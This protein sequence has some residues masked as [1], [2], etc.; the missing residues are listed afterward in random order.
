MNIPDPT[1]NPGP[2]ADSTTPAS[3]G[4]TSTPQVPAGRLHGHRRSI[5]RMALGAAGVVFGD[6]GT[7]P[8]YA[9]KET[10]GAHGLA[11]N[12]ANILGVLSLVFWALILVASIK[13]A[14]FILRP[15]N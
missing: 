2:A 11:V 5:A 6:I 10:F 3:M 1:A 14:F 15:A 9:I 13:Y 7:S 4:A 12:H 8:L